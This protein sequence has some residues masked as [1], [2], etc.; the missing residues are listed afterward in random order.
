MN[1]VLKK[2]F[3]N[4][5]SGSALILYGSGSCLLSEC[6]SRSSYE[7]ECGYRRMR[8]RIRKTV[9]KI[10]IQ[11]A[12]TAAKLISTNSNFVECSRFL[13]LMKIFFLVRAV[14]TCIASF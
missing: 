6:G 14:S 9:D 3:I 11:F 10:G 4:N 13:L 12:I 7:V 8:I 5:V 1:T 2:M